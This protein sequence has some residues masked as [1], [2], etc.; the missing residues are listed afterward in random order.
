[1][2]KTWFIT[3]AS[4]GFGREWTEAALERGDRVAAT[5]RR[6]ETLDALVETYGDD[7]LPIAARRDRPRRRLRGRA[8]RRRSF[9][10]ARRRRQQRR[11]RPLRNGRG[12]ERGRG[13]LADSRRTCSGRSGSPRPPCR[14]CARRARGH[15]IQVSSIGGI[16]AFTGI[17]RLPRVEVGPR[18]LLPVAGAG[19]RGVRDPRDA[20]RAGRIL[21]RLGRP[22][23]DAQ[24]G[25]PGLR[26]SARSTGGAPGRQRPGR[27]RRRRALRSSRSSTR[28]NRRCA[29]SSARR[30]SRPRGGTTRRAWRPGTSGS[31]SRSR[32]SARRRRPSRVPPRGGDMVARWR[33]TSTAS[34]L[35]R[36]SRHCWASPS[37]WRAARRSAASTGIAVT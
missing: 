3:G 14:S 4:K 8:A 28:P 26:R 1:M 13:A 7:V 15:I 32:P 34:R 5:A 11:L 21:D 10:P 17:G 36:R 16:T 25:E 37:N 2:S 18:G 30:L 35:R 19:G 27:S 22:V 24:R 31:P 23:G 12:A 20:D 29:S 9:R 33:S 6:L